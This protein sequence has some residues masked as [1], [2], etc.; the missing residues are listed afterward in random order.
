MARSEYSNKLDLAT[1]QPVIDASAEY[2][3]LAQTFKAQDVFWTPP[4]A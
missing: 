4:R 1:I 3:F 2:H